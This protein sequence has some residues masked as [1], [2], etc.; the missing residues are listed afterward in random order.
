[1]GELLRRIHYLLHRRRFDAELESDME[2]HREMAGREGGC[3]FG[4]ELRM[5]EQAREAWG[6]MWLDRLAQDLRWASRELRRAPGS[7]LAMIV[8]LALGMGGVT[9]LFGPLYSLVLRPLPFPHSDRLVRISGGES[10]LDL[11]ANHSFFK[12]RRSLDPIFSD[13][14]A[15]SS[16]PSTLSGGGPSERVD[17]VVAT[18]EF[19]VTLGVQPRLGRGF[20]P[21]PKVAYYY[22]S[23]D[24]PG[25]IISDKLWRTRLQSTRDLSHASVTLDGSRVAVIGV[26]PPSFDFPSGTQVWCAGHLTI[27]PVLIGRLRPGLSMNQAQLGLRTVANQEASASGKLNPTLKSLHDALLG[28]RKPLLWILSTVS[29]LFLA[30]ACAG[31]ANLLLARGVRRRQ[32]MV[33]RSVLGA[34]RGRLVRQLLT[35][36]LLLAAAGGLLGLGFSALARHGLQLLFPEIMKDAATFSTAT[37]ALVI[38]LT[39][40]ATILCGV[41]PAFHATA[42]DLNSSLKA[43]SQASSGPAPRRHIPSGHELFAGAQLILAMVLLISTGLLLRSMVARLNYPLGFDPKNIAVVN[44]ALPNPAVLREA[45][46]EYSRQHPRSPRTHLEEEVYRQ[47]TESENEAVV[48]LQETFYQE[49]TSR[50]IELPGVVSVAAMSTPPFAKGDTLSWRQ[51]LALFDPIPGTHEYAR[52]VIGLRREVSVGAFSLLGIQLLAGRDFLPSDIPAPDGWKLSM[53]HYWDNAA[54]PVRAV[55]VNETF[56]HEAWP[57]QNPLGQTFRMGG[58]ARVVGVVADIHE[59][60]QNPTI[61][62]TLYEPFTANTTFVQS[63]TFIVKLRPG[64]NLADLKKALPPVDPDA[65]PPTVMPLQESLG[66]LS[67]ALSLLGCFSALGIIVAGLGVYATATLMAAAATRETGIRLTIGASAE[68][69]GRLTLWRSLRLALLS[70]PVG[71]LGA[72][73]LGGNLKHWLFQVGAG[74]PISYLISAAV[75]LAIA[76]A[77]GLWPALRAATTDPAIALRYDG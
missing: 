73:L 57:N 70:L 23:S 40:A 31:V 25:V 5:R 16:R 22:D 37:I 63:V 15:Y 43:G 9:A 14:M 7:A 17:V 44:V 26:M 19:F 8:L 67:I 2:F 62:P 35:E 13:V 1:V 6:W 77:A 3:N 68:Q 51:A 36:T 48:A 47:A 24:V 74:D 59:S 41:A 46:M 76:L 50:L 12:S 55:I 20:P 53:Y 32:E 18:Q 33:V 61:L 72:W 45:R 10:L 4:N 29:F 52:A 28:D 58:S 27:M 71:A 11:Y 69:I 65:A 21:D 34:E 54:R 66:N 75:L 56:A 42:A 60:R 49:A 38:A 39:L 64:A 30:L